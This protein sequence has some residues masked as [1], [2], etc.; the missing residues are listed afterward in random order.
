M[1]LHIYEYNLAGNLQE[2]IKYWR[3]YK[4]TIN[5]LCKELNIPEDIER[6]IT[7]TKM[8]FGTLCVLTKF[9]C[10]RLVHTKK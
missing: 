7:P 2:Q 8:N 10:R 9:V 1:Q 3:Y 6:L 5:N 4:K